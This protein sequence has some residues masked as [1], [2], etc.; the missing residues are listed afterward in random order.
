MNKTIAAVATFAALGAGALSVHA[1]DLKGSDT[2]KKL[3]VQVVAACPGAAGVIN[4]VGGGSGAGENA[5]IAGTQAVS[6]MSR[7]LAGSVAS[8]V[9]AVD[10][11]NAEAIEIAGD[12][13]VISMNNMHQTA[14]DPGNPGAANDACQGYS[15]GGLNHSR[16]L[17]TGV[18]LTSWKDTLRLVYLG[19]APNDFPL[20]ASQNGLTTG[21]G[22]QVLAANIA[23][24]DCEDPSRVELVNHFGE[25]FNVDCGNDG[26]CTKLQHA[27]RRDEN[28]GT[29]DFF[30]ETLGVESG[31]QFGNKG[32]PFCNEYVPAVTINAANSGNGT[33][34]TTNAD[35]T[36]AGYGLCSGG[37]CHRPN[38]GCTVATSA[39]DCASGFSCDPGQLQCAQTCAVGNDATC[40]SVIP[41]AT[42][43]AA[44]VCKPGTCATDADCGGTAGSCDTSSGSGLCRMPPSKVSCTAATQC[45][46]V[47]ATCT[48]PSDMNASTGWCAALVDAPA[49]DTKVEARCGLPGLVGGTQPGTVA[50]VPGVFRSATA[51]VGFENQ[52]N[53]DPVRRHVIGSNKLTGAGGGAL[54]ANPAE[55]VATACGDNGVVLPIS[56]PSDAINSFPNTVCGFGK[57]NFFPAVQIVG[58]ANARWQLCPN[59]DMP[60]GATGWDPVIRGAIRGSGACLTPVKPTDP[61]SANCLS[62]SSNRPAAAFFQPPSTYVTLHAGDPTSVVNVAAIDARVYNLDVWQPAAGARLAQSYEFNGQEQGPTPTPPDTATAFNE[63]VVGAF[64]RIHSTRTAKGYTNATVVC[65]ANADC[66]AATPTCDTALHAC[67]TNAEAGCT[68]LGNDGTANVCCETGQDTNQIGCLAIASPCSMGYAGLASASCANNSEQLTTQPTAGG[69]QVV[70]T[71]FS[72]GLDH[73]AVGGVVKE[74]TGC[75][76]STAC[77]PAD[78][79]TAPTA[80]QYPIARDLFFSSIKGFASPTVTAGELALGQCLSGTTP[81]TSGTIN[82]LIDANGFVSNLGNYACCKDFKE[83]GCTATSGS[84]VNGCAANSAVNMPTNICAF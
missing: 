78:G 20:A 79:I 2:L 70:E 42:C 38:N 75:E 30:R 73:T 68:N 19:L 41:S 23:R 32:F 51:G 26:G 16:T 69:A 83:S 66:P 17:G 45:P 27:F 53:N 14:C 24:R 84:S 56:E 82:S 77:I 6:P 54:D 48:I 35:C 46:G 10:T 4:Y 1:F 39:T 67:F 18:T 25:L 76:A 12:A 7:F 49:S 37:T 64:Y 50:A 62:G 9:C 40:S 81:L 74:V 55:Q 34:C 80:L 59:G 61:N 31:T 71:N 36:A 28:S 33:A 57:V 60:L 47:G 29:T 21:P 3:T 8:G 15:S 65:N 44:G 5:M 72:V 43:H 52:Q 58:G 13:I 22:D 11:T 63:A